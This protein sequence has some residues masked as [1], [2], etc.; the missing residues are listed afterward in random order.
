MKH[1]LTSISAIVTFLCCKP[2]VEAAFLHRKLIL[3]NAADAIDGRYIV[4]FQQGVDP[5]DVLSSIPMSR[6]T[7]ES[8]LKVLDGEPVSSTAV[9]QDIDEGEL[10]NLLDDPGVLHI[11]PVS[12]VL[13]DTSRSKVSHPST[14]S[15][16]PTS[17]CAENQLAIRKLGS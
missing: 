5:F 14:G 2:T 7:G 6:S 17:R 12:M 16:C 15:A 8:Y 11:E 3:G 10:L 13:V 4:S 1:Q 9:L